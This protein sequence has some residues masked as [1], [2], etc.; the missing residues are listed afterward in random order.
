LAAG[1]DGSVY[2]ADGANGTI[3]VIRQAP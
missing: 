1:T 2:A 3:R